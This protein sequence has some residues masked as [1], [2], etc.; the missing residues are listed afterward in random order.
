LEEIIAMPEINRDEINKIKTE[1]KNT[2]TNIERLETKL[3][4]SSSKSGELTVYKQNALNASN[5]KESAL[6]ILK[7]LED[8]KN[9]LERKYADQEKKFESSKGHK[10]VRKDDLIQKAENMKKKK[11]IFIKYSKVLD[12]YIGETLVLDKTVRILK[13]KSDDYESI[14]QRVEEKQ[15]VSGYKNAKKELEELAKKKNEIDQSKALTLEE[16]SKLILQ[17][18][19][20]I[21]DSQDKHAPHIDKL[22]K[23]KS[24]YETLLPTYNQKKNSYE[25]SISDFQNQYNKAKDEFLKLEADYKSSQNK[26]HTLHMSI[27]YNDEMVKRYETENYYMSKPD[28]RLNEKYKSHSEYYKAFIVEQENYLKDLKQQQADIKSNYDDNLRQVR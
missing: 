7:K 8:E 23:I 28:K 3:K 5:L 26:Y 22:N 12:A 19:Q 21:K 25:M 6:K 1:I 17:F 9:L 11:E 4:N 2:Q 13:T 10:F 14:L 18:Q 24:E 15:G 20:K 27:K 16:Y